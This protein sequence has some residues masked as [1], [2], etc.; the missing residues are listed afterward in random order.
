MGIQLFSAALTFEWESFFA[1]AWRGILC[2]AC[3]VVGVR[4]RW[5]PVFS[6][7]RSNARVLT[8][9]AGARAEGR[10]LETTRQVAGEEL[11][12]HGRQG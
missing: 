10:L 6:V 9:G 4:V 3:S 8:L 12:P 5:S 7:R 11:Q 1:L 2:M